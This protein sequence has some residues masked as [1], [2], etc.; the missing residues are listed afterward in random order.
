MRVCAVKGNKLR[1]RHVVDLAPAQAEFFLR[2]HDDAAAFGRFVGQGR[3][4]GRSGQLL[5]GH[6]RGWR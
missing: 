2:Q 5:L 6:A 1:V 3:E 4:L